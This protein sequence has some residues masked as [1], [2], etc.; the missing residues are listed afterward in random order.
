MRKSTM[1]M[2]MTMTALQE[3]EK[4]FENAQA[5][6]RAALMPYF[7]LGYPT[8]EDSLDVLFVDGHGKVI[9]GAGGHGLLALAHLF[10]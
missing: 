6:N 8:V 3:I 1:T 7:T 4:A 5:E 2:N 9:S 10:A